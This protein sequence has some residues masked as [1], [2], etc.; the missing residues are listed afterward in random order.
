MLEL[1]PG[2]GASLVRAVARLVEQGHIERG[3]SIGHAL[4]AIVL[5]ILARYHFNS[6]SAG[7]LEIC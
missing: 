3:R 1:A 5:Y 4:V 6:V 2:F 7:N